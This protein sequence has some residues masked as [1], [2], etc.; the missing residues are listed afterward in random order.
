VSTTTSS[1]RV[2]GSPTDKF[3]LERGLRQDDHLSPFI[4]LIVVEQLNIMLNVNIEAD[5]FF[6]SKIGYNEVVCISHLH[7]NVETLIIRENSWANIRA[8]KVNFILFEIISKPNLD[9][10]KSM[11]VRVNVF[12]SWLT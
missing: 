2:N 7:F 9:F 3:N 4:F 6:G 11:L 12:E 5:L 10:N 1:V 8:L